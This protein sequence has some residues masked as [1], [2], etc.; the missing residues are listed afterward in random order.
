MFVRQHC[1]TKY[2]LEEARKL[3]IE[4]VVDVQGTVRVDNSQSVERFLANARR[5]RQKEDWEETE[6]YYNM[7]E[8]NDPNNIEAVFYSA[9]AKARTSLQQNDHNKRIAAFNIFGKSISVIDDYFDTNNIDAQIEMVKTMSTDMMTMYTCEK[10]RVIVPSN[11]LN[12]SQTVYESTAYPYTNRL[13]KAACEKF[14]ESLQHIIDSNEKAKLIYD[15][16]A[17]QVAKEVGG[18]AASAFSMDVDAIFVTGGMAYDKNFCKILDS[19]LGKIA[20]VCVYPG[21]DEMMAL[22]LNGLMVLNGETVAK[23]Y[24]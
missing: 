14:I 2:S 19:H 4:G 24:E 1:G 3:M 18:L 11:S 5:A 13:L 10:V 17:Y 12:A 7:V 6:K 15:A 9:Y 8:Q 22:T 23:I 16:M 21:E 20:P